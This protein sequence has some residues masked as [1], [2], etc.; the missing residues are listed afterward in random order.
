MK[1]D[2]DSAV[3]VEPGADDRGHSPRPGALQNR[4]TSSLK[5][6]RIGACLRAARTGRR[7]HRVSRNVADRL[8]LPLRLREAQIPPRSPFPGDPPAGFSP[9]AASEAA[10]GEKPYSTLIGGTFFLS[11][12]RWR[13]MVASA[14]KQQIPIS[15]TI[16]EL[17]SCRRIVMRT[18]IIKGF[19][20]HAHSGNVCDLKHLPAARARFVV[21]PRLTT[22]QGGIFSGTYA[23][24]GRL[25][26]SEAAITKQ[27]P[28]RRP[29]RYCGLLTLN[30]PSRIFSCSAVGSDNSTML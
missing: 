19:I 29:H 30:H 4:G 18:T 28:P 21:S 26:S 14:V 22:T 5:E 27:A 3:S 7:P 1:V 9:W 25:D 6:V 8:R 23:M 10:Q 16:S 20:K 24:T 12:R 2:A 17:S 13:A 15:K 11:K